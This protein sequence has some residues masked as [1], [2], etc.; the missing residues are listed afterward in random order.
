MISVLSE[1]DDHGGLRRDDYLFALRGGGQ[2][3]VIDSCRCCRNERTA[4]TSATFRKFCTGAR[5]GVATNG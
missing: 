3:G 5:Q 1:P 4:R 2:T